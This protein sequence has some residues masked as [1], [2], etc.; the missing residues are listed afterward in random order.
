MG[1]QTLQQYRDD[2]GATTP[3]MLQRSN[4]GVTLIDKWVNQAL[5]EFG[6]AFKFHELEASI[7]FN[8]LLGVPSYDLVT[9]I[10]VTDFRYV[11]ELWITDPDTGVITRVRPE[12]RTKY[13]KNLGV[14]T[15]TGTYGL[16]RWYHRHAGEIFLRPTPD[17]VYNV[18][19]DYYKTIE[20]LDSDG[21]VSPFHED[22]DEAILVGALYRGFRHFGEFDRYQNVRNDFL[23]L[24]RSRQSE[25]ELEEFPEGGI[26]PLG[27]HDTQDVE[28]AE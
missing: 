20:P 16:P 17:K 9:L 4:I 12:T 27:P 22:W 6:Y 28:E 8:T 25:Y 10:Q 5:R 19:M 13:R 26:S 24:V 3:G 7:A 2:L 21:S 23:A 14:P 18:S 1:T 11:D 15:D